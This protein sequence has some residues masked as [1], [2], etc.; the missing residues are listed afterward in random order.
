MVALAIQLRAAE[1]DIAERTDAL[2]RG[3]DEVL[4][5]LEEVRE[6]A[7]GIHPA[8]LTEAGLGP[9]IQAAA[10]RSPIPVDV[11]L[12]LSGTGSAAAIATVYFV[13]SEAFANVIKHAGQL[14]TAAWIT[15]EDGDGWLRIVVDD[16]GPGGADAAGHGLGGLADRVAALDGRFSV[17]ARPGGGTR[18]SAEIPIA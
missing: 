17:G 7:R 8:V 15:A 14:A 16:D 11:S 5:I 4:G 6:L 2:R 18:V 3:A 1:S 13:A 9:A 10:D 12:R